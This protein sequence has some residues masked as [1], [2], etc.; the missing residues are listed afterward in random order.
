MAVKLHRCPNLWVKV[1]GHPCWKVQKALDDQGIDYE[2]APGPWPGRKKRTVVIEGTGQ[3][4]YPAIEFD[5]G[6]WYR[7]ESKEMERTIREGRL[8]EKRGA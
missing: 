1:K 4:L 3:A 6:T 8:L 5:D 7:E 2:V